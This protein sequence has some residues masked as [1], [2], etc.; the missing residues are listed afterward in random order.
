[1]GHKNYLTNLII[2]VV[3]LFVLTRYGVTAPVSSPT[4]SNAQSKILSVETQ[5]LLNQIQILKGPALDLIDKQLGD[6]VQEVV[7]S[8]KSGNSGVV[9][10]A[11][12]EQ[13]L[14]SASALLQKFDPG[15]SLDKAILNDF[16]YYAI[17]AIQRIII[18]KGVAL[19][20]AKIA[21]SPKQL[22]DII[23]EE[24][25]R[26]NE[27]KDT[28]TLW[29]SFG[30]SGSKNKVEN[31]GLGIVTYYLV[32]QGGIWKLH[33]SFFSLDPLSATELETITTNMKTLIQ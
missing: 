33:Y 9:E 12:T 29:T 17:I 16:N 21:Y 22:L 15:T 4:T 26:A 5:K 8:A 31:N 6:S 3:A 20:E 10:Q 18:D 11:I 24:K 1:M 30:G 32:L 14:K 23:E 19:V 13:Y 28:S 25:E 7:K 27:K 2:V